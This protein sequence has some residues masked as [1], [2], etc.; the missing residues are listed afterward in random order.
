MTEKTHHVSQK[1][2]DIAKNIERLILEYP[3]IAAVDM[4]N[5][6]APQLQQMRSQLRGK[7]EL[8]MTKRRVMKHAIEEVKDKKKN[9]ELL[10]PLLKGMP[11]LI[12]TKENPFSLFKT[13]KKSKTSAPAKAGQKA[14]F[15]IKIP[16]GPTPFAPGPVIGELAQLHIK[17]GVEGGKVVIKEDSVVVKEGEKISQKAA[18]ILTRLGIEPMEV[19]LNVTAVYENG[20]IF[21][22]NI[23]D[24]DEEKFS[25]DLAKA[26][27]GALN[28]ALN[29]EYP[30]KETITILIGNAFNDAKALGLSQNIIDD[31]IIDALLAKAEGSALSLKSTANIQTVDKQA[32]PKKEEKAPKPEE[33]KPAKEEV[34]PPKETKVE[35]KKAKETKVE[36]PE[37]K[38]EEPKAE[39]KIE[40]SKI[41]ERPLPKEGKARVEEPKEE[42]PQEPE[43][44]TPAPT[45]LEEKEKKVL[46]EEKEILKEEKKLEKETKEPKIE[47]PVEE[48]VKKQVK[49][50]EEKELEKERIA[51]EKEFEKVQSTDNKVADMVAKTKQFVKGK[52]PSAEKLVE[53]ASP[54]K[55]KEKKAPKKEKVPSIQ[56]L[57]EKKEKKKKELADVEN[58]AK[59]LVK[60]GTLRK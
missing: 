39:E 41:E 18:E 16:K 13:L 48:E 8:T 25:A 1:K 53:Q 59:E 22:R 17:S 15:D 34:K 44:Q 14:P 56:E 27:T 49:E 3:I 35:E 58:L 11:A 12:F 36:P 20:E 54:E 42:K 52:V 24:I 29:I 10:E 37:K 26:A 19:G 43:K 30:T 28:L 46:E 2:K 6:P 21:T 7:I 45:K 33:Q 40:A 57:K 5:L 4:E 9:I 23:L 32:E 51:K 50:E 31:G 60:K 38:P 55:P 47:A